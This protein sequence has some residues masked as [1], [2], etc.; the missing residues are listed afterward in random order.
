MIP[1]LSY[2]GRVTEDQT[3]PIAGLSGKV[4]QLVS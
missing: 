2:F 1:D 4:Q 3:S